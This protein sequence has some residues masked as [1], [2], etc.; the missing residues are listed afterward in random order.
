MEVLGGVPS[1]LPSD[2]CTA[3]LMFQLV[4]DRVTKAMSVALL[5]MNNLDNSKQKRSNLLS[6]A[7]LPY[8]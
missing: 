2:L 1:P 6:P 5:L 4:L 8:S 7:L 3:Q